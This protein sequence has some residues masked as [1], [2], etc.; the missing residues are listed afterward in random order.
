M[1][2]RTK[3]PD[4]RPRLTCSGA[5]ILNNRR[6]CAGDCFPLVSRNLAGVDCLGEL[7][8]R[9]LCCIRLGRIGHE[10]IRQRIHHIQC[11][12]C[13]V[14][15]SFQACRSADVEFLRLGERSVCPVGGTEQSGL[16]VF[17]LFLACRR[18]TNPVSHLLIGLDHAGHLAER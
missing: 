17:I 1:P 4:F 16:Y 13:V 2:L 6:D 9:C 11:R 14:S 8:D 12:R 10:C 15:E 18:Q 3:T 7:A 5:D